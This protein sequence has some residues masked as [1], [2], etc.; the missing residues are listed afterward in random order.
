MV[1]ET[2]VRGDLQQCRAD[3]ECVDRSHQC[4]RRRADA[5]GSDEAQS[6]AFSSCGESRREEARGH[7]ALDGKT[8]RRTLGHTA[9]DQKKIHQL[10][11]Y[12]TQTGVLLKEQVT[13]EKPE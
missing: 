3:V 5:R 4:L 7:V 8:L 13:G 1:V 6:G 11:L 2:A 12:D 10:T 9:A